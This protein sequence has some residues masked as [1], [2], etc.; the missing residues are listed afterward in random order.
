MQEFKKEIKQEMQEFKN[1]IKQEMQEFKN[2]IR[3]EIENLVSKKEFYSE[4]RKLSLSLTVKMGVIMGAGI[5]IIG[6]L[7][8]I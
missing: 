5:T 8:K 3:G 7:T 1:E 4:M 6:V 2:E